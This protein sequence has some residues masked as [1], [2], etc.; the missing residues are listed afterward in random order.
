MRS[1]GTRAPFLVKVLMFF[2]FVVH[3]VVRGDAKG[4][5]GGN[6]I[7]LQ[8]G[9]TTDNL[10]LRSRSR[11]GAPTVESNVGSLSIHWH[12]MHR[13]F[14][15]RFIVRRPPIM[16]ETY[17]VGNT[18]NCIWG[19]Y[20]WGSGARW[21]IKRTLISS[22]SSQSTNQRQR[23]CKQGNSK[24]NRKQNK[25]GGVKQ[26]IITFLRTTFCIC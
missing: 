6:P 25:E 12:L 15:V 14:C 5:F 16:K 22:R 18:A 20:P 24:R 21:Q 1:T 19:A 17:C 9:M 10:P 3:T 13:F 2:G 26:A 23:W 7:F 8:G 4:V 11:D